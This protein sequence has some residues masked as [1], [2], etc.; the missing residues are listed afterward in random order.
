M[1][2]TQF[3]TWDQVARRLS[4]TGIDLRVDHAPSDGFS[5][6]NDAAS[7]YVLTFLAPR[8]PVAL[9][10]T[11][12]WV[13]SITADIC[14]WYLEQWRNNPVSASVEARKEMWDKMLEMILQNKM[15]VPD[16]TIG[17]DRPEII[18]QRVAANQYPSMRVVDAN[19]SSY[20]PSGFT[21]YPDRTEPRQS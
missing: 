2:V 1:A 11:S 14:I 16:I 12:N 10:A 4:A 5:E 19:S 17:A 9:L 6:A 3:T 18:Q 21:R 20:R 15:S 7:L 8:Y 13:A